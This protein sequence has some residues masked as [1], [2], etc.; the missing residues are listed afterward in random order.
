LSGLSGYPGTKSAACTPPLLVRLGAAVIPLALVTIAALWRVWFLRQGVLA[1]DKDEAIVGLMGLYILAGDRPVFFY[2]Q[3]YLGSA[4]AY[5]HAAVFAILGA[6]SITL[7]IVPLLISL[8]C[9]YLVYRLGSTLYSRDIGII[10]GVYLALSPVFFTMWS[11]RA[12]LAFLELLAIGTALILLALRLQRGC[13]P[14]WLPFLFGLLLGL[15][16]WTNQ[17]ILLYIPA[18][19]ILLVG[20]PTRYGV[21]QTMIAGL[22]TFI[23][24]LPLWLTNISHGNGTIRNL[25]AMYTSQF[26]GLP[27]IPGYREMI[28]SHLHTG[29]PVLTGF[30]QPHDPPIDW[31]LLIPYP[32]GDR[33][34]PIAICTTL[35]LIAAM[36]VIKNCIQLIK[37]DCTASMQ[38]IRGEL[39]LAMHFL[40]VPLI[41]YAATISAYQAASP[42]YLLLLYSCVPLFVN[43]VMRGIEWLLARVKQIC[44]HIFL[45][46][47]INDA[48]TWSIVLFTLAIGVNV[49]GHTGVQYSW[50]A[51]LSDEHLQ[52]LAH[53]LYQRDVTAFYAE[54]WITYPLMFLSRGQ[55]VGSLP[56]CFWRIDSDHARVAAA[57]KGAWIVTDPRTEASVL[58][59][60]QNAGASYARENMVGFTVIY[61][62]VPTSA[63][64]ICRPGA[65]PVPAA[66]ASAEPVG[67]A[68]PE[69]AAEQAP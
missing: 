19:F 22:G 17:L 33:I 20:K 61:D 42:R 68:G 65:P 21:I 24:G 56:G 31:N 25:Q 54:D 50:T 34:A 53:Y 46:L 30:F 64:P 51:K 11:L 52:N 10:S 67:D 4:E 40:A 2:G 13:A 39:A 32:M 6:S 37:R 28:I 41:V 43:A 14:P 9:V 47:W 44:A 66:G 5:L 1:I 29:L 49:R 55:L 38:Y 8:V 35:V 3:S 36:L 62:V 57:P 63:L 48:H 27:G 15:G 59:Q 12:R 69:S 23:G 45:P 58:E 60:L 26:P 18:L 16:L 7:R